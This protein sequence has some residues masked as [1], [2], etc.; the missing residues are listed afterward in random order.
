MNKKAK[1]ILVVVGIIVVLILTFLGY[2]R[3][4]EFSSFQY[5]AP[6]G[7]QYTLKYFRDGK[8]VDSSVLAK[9]LDSS[10]IEAGKSMLVSY[11][12][13]DLGIAINISDALNKP[14]TK[15][16][17]GTD[18]FAFSVDDY[19]V[20]ELTKGSK[21][22]ALLAKVGNDG[23][24]F[25]VT[26]VAIAD[27]KRVTVS[28]DKEYGQSVIDFNLMDYQKQLETILKSIQPVN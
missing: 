25:V 18:R 6:K 14:F 19:E 2:T 27:G 17:T 23:K 12:V 7:Q 26:I 21:Q 28:K 16:C 24:Y 1:I 3:F 20:C 11:P 8:I 9:K 4:L 15:T 5:T 10:E 22:K 13:E